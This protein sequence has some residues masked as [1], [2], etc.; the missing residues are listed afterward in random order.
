MKSLFLA[1]RV[2]ANGRRV[3]ASQPLDAPVTFDWELPEQQAGTAPQELWDE[4]CVLRDAGGWFAVNKPSGI[5]SVRLKGRG[6]ESLEDWL[7]ANEPALGKLPEHGLVNR[8]DQETSGVVLVAR[9]AGI[10]DH[11][12]G[13]I[14][15]AEKIYW[16]AVIG[17]PPDSGSI[18]FELRA[19]S[20][21]SGTVT[22]FG[23]R[24]QRTGETRYRVIGR[25]PGFSLLEVQLVGPGARHQIRAH[26]SGE[27]FPVAGDRLYKGDLPDAPTRLALHAWRLRLPGEAEPVVAPVPRALLD[28]WES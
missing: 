3:K 14:A 1:G 7:A 4:I 6:G 2:R 27:G 17:E 8:L 11:L 18:D 5:H 9:D 13:S 16:T 24:A 23:R 21:A 22:R 12:R 15:S 20:R 25:K 19:A 26:L 28:W 10:R